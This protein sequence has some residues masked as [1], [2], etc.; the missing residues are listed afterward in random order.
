M[1]A[2][3]Y[4]S[5]AAFVQRVQRGLTL[6]RLLQ[7]CLL[8]GTVC[9]AV[10]LLGVGV[11]ALVTS[12]PWV[13]LLYSLLALGIGAYLVLYGLWPLL[14]P[15]SLRQTLT[16]IETAYPDLHDD[17]TNA[18]QLDPAALERSNPQGMALDMVQALHQHT[19]RQMEQCTVS[20]VVRQSPL[21]V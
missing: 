5:L 21:S 8:L 18:V 9:L 16:Q 10:L 20:A 19:A 2:Q 14:R 7:N 12:A 15:L 1:M 4:R 3:E 17:L 11:Q 6:R 13:A